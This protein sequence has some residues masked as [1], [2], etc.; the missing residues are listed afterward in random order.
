MES[1]TTVGEHGAHAD[2]TEWWRRHGGAVDQSL[3]EGG[4]E[5]GRNTTMEEEPE[6]ALLVPEVKV[7]MMVG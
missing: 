6:V 5:A 4:E 7:V 3:E 2:G 1:T